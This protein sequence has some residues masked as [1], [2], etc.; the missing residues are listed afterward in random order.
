MPSASE[1]MSPAWA[2]ECHEPTSSSVSAGKR[3]DERNVFRLVRKRQRA[4]FIFQQHA[5]FGRRLARQR[6]ARPA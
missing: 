2:R 3:P 6:H 1:T 5:G 4:V